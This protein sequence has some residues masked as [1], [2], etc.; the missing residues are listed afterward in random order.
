MIQVKKLYKCQKA[1]I[2]KKERKKENDYDVKFSMYKEDLLAAS[3][4]LKDETSFK[5]YMYLASNQDNYAFGLSRADVIEQT[6]MGSKSYDRAVSKL[7]D[8]GYLVYTHEQAT[9][10]KITAPLYDFI[11]RPNP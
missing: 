11:A 3:R 5:L 9:D 8:N 4:T 6:G 7:I 1:V 10:G 2:I